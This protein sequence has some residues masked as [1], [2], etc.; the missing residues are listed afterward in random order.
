MYKLVKFH[1]VCT[2]KTTF[3]NRYLFTKRKLMLGTL[4]MEDKNEIVLIVGENYN[5][6]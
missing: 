6:Y 1:L 5:N 4:V 3:C 2:D